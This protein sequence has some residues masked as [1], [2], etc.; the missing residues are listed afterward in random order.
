[1][2]PKRVV[3]P[4]PGTIIL[5]ELQS[6]DGTV[7]Q[8]ANKLEIP[9]TKVLEILHGVKDLDDDLCAKLSKIFNT[10]IEFWLA[11]QSN[12]NNQVIKKY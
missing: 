10:S 4:H 7:K 6:V 2:I 9:E 3:M 1:M 11:L 5:N 8:L 12:Y